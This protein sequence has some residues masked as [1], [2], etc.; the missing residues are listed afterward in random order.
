MRRAKALK[1]WDEVDAGFRVGAA[2]K[3]FA[4]GSRGD[5][6]ETVA[7]PLHRSAGHEDRSF[8]RECAPALKL[9]KHGRQHACG[10]GDV[11]VPGIGENEAA[12][13][14]GRLQHTWRKTPLSVGRGLLVA[15][16]ASDRDVCAEMLARGD[17]E[18]SLAVA[19]LGKQFARNA[20]PVE[21]P[22]V[23]VP[24]A[25]VVEHGPGGV[26]RVDCMDLAVGEL[27]KE[28]AV[29]RT[30]AYLSCL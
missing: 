16:D 29:D 9:M 1:G 17:A 4:R 14:I 15:S 20:K 24:G 12:R 11:D 21:Q 6:S 27:E 3:V 10:R 23:P 28:E 5:Q 13:A 18:F 26:T 22:I 7:E 19:Q 2:G 8:Q 25:D 30:E